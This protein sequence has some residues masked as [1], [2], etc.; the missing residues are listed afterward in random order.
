MDLELNGE[1]NG[2]ARHSATCLFLDRESLILLPY[3]Q[4]QGYINMSTQCSEMHVHI[5]LGSS[6][7]IQWN[8]SVP[9]PL[10]S[11]LLPLLALSHSQL[12]SKV[13]LLHFSS[14]LCPLHG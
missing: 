8:T 11:E 12:P 7:Q 4:Y 9:Y 3:P 2:T 10:V 13:S 14:Y 1:T 6:F 5:I